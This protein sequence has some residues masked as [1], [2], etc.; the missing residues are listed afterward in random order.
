MKRDEF[1]KKTVGT[2]ILAMTVF[3]CGI[4]TQAATKQT[5]VVTDYTSQ[6][7]WLSKPTPAKDVAVFYLY[8]TAW[9]GNTSTNYL[10]DASNTSM[11]SQAKHWQVMQADCFSD[12]ADI[13]AP[14]YRQYDANYVL[15]QPNGFQD[16]TDIPYED[17]VNAFEY[18]LDNFAQ[19]RPFILAGHSQGSSITMML[20][21]DY[22]KNHPDVYERMIAAYVIGYGVT[23]TDLAENPH[24]KYAQG[25]GDTGCIISYNTEAPNVTAKNPVIFDGSIAINPITW[26]LTG[27]KADKS[28]SLGAM[29]PQSYFS[30]TL[31]AKANMCDAQVNVSRGSV[32]ISS[33]S[34]ST[35]SYTGSWAKIFPSGMY[36]QY[37]YSFFYN[38]LRANAKLREDNYFEALR[39]KQQEENSFE[40]AA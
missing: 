26:T 7:N 24:L 6:S 35:Y 25:A 33:I 12:Y 36:H 23:A 21:K 27:E 28:L 1:V 19:D 32:M 40:Q 15:A 13:Y 16:C 9:S 34:Q 18:F 3:V 11:R 4:Q 38:D 20:L 8:P 5:S 10:A 30:N 22:M 31:T 39:Q 29:M 17:A 37:D 14:Y 2:I